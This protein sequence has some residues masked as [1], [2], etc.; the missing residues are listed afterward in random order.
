MLFI[1]DNPDLNESEMRTI[2]NPYLKKILDQ[3]IWFQNDDPNDCLYL[4]L[5]KMKGG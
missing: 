3:L 2:I 4:D 5:S 1:T